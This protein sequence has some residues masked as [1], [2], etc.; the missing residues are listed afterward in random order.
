M[1]KYIILL[2]LAILVSAI[3]AGCAAPKAEQPIEPDFTPQTEIPVPELVIPENP[4][5]G[6]GLK[7]DGTPY[8]FAL[9]HFYML[10]DFQVCAEGISHTLMDRAGAELT[11]YDS[12]GDAN[13]QIGI[14]EDL[15]IIGVD[16]INIQAADSVAMVPSTEKAIAAGIPI[17]MWDH[18]VNT[19]QYISFSTH[20]QVDCG[21][22]CGKFMVEQAEKKGE[23][24]NVY[25][26]WGATGHE[27]AQR[28]H[29]GFHEIVDQYPDLITVME[30]PDS[31]WLTE[32][33]MSFVQDAF[34][35]NPELGALY[36]HGSL[37]GGT[38]GLRNANRLFPPDDPRHVPYASIDCFPN[39]LR[40]MRA[41][42]VDIVAIH[43]PWEEAD[44]ATK[45]MLLYV[46]CGKPVPKDIFF[47]SGV[48]N[49]ENMYNARYGKGMTW[50]DWLT[51]V[52]DFNYWPILD[53]P[54]IIETPTVNM[55]EPGF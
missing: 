33:M 11:S 13:K 16:G 28:R 15:V 50:G 5:E 32:K 12:A 30:S 38:E 34:S 3:L 51:E 55:K 25:E 27:G 29:D 44:G 9:V 45:A 4:M 46:C 17:F 41:G 14:M 26:T 52:P 23:T 31:E 8:N 7:P 53:Y 47:T 35:A 21:R 43:D 36:L 2:M 39:I 42:Y 49:R 20:D 10:S 40:D 6:V 37:P 22:I 18:G 54:G 1:R 19:D 48:V 24:L